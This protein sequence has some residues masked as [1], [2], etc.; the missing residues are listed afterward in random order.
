MSNDSMVQF[1]DIN[2]N[3]VSLDLGS[4]D[5]VVFNADCMELLRVLPD[6]CIDLAIVDPPYGITAPKGTYL[7]RAPG[8]SNNPSTAE[9]VRKRAGSLKGSGKL[10]NRVL[11]ISDTDW[12]NTPPRR[13][14][15]MSCSGF[16]GIRSSG[17]VTTLTFLR[18]DALLSGINVSRG[19]ISHRRNMHGQATACQARSS[20]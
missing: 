12:D 20:P 2:G 13:N 4:V 19:R 1:H 14:I 9:L 17:A 6:K 5:S 15:S 10:K 7:S 8:R 16:Q 11:N 3:T 18:Q